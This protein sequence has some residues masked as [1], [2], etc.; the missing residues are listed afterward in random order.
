MAECFVLVLFPV[1]RKTDYKT[2]ID[3][4]KDA[5][6]WPG[7]LLLVCGLLQYAFFCDSLGR[8]WPLMAKDMDRH[9][10]RT[11]QFDTGMQRRSRIGLPIKCIL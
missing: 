4:L 11:A 10:L 2:R 1:S 9:R 5:D 6:M 3:A 8:L 7:Q